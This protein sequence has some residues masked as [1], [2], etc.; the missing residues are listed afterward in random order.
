MRITGEAHESFLKCAS[1]KTNPAHKGAL[2][3]KRRVIK[4]V[5]LAVW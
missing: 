4:A 5:D 3:E 1:D 2:K